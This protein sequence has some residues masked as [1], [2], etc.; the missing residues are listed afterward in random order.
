MSSK[1]VA[2]VGCYTHEEDDG[3]HI[4]DV[5]VEKGR[6]T[7]RKTAALTNSTYVALSHNGKYLYSITDNG[8][9]SF[10][11]LPDGDLE[12]INVHTINGMRGCHLELTKDDRYL[13]V[14]GYHD[15]KI[16]ILRCSED[17]SID[18]ITDEVFHKG[19]GSI[20]ERNY[21][22]HIMWSTFTPDEELL[23]AC[24]SGIDQIKIYNFDH[25]TGK[26]KLYDIIR[27]Q[28]ETAPREIVFSPDGKHAYV[29]CEMK[30]YINVY[31][32][33]KEDGRYTFEFVQNIFTVRKQFKT[34]NAPYHFSIS[35]D[36]KH[37]VCTNAGSNS[38]T[39]YEIKE[40]GMLSMLG[41]LPVS[42]NYPKFAQIFPD[43]KHV[44]CMNTEGNS[45]TFFTIHWDKGLI[46]MNGPEIKIKTPNNMVMKKL[47]K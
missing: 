15:G 27:T 19:L 29:V 46:V 16:T 4:F 14:S 17:G 47:D 37:A 1:Y 20:S 11:V 40:D 42:G 18:C 31:D 23:C 33:K 25:R 43:D 10:S 2:Y 7:E 22:P 35:N 41:N 44:C 39:M 24:D 6:M 12:M 45:I 38:L 5:D 34:N 3:I 36:G 21:R 9:A 32:Y 30:N 8:V 26:L 28:L 13:A